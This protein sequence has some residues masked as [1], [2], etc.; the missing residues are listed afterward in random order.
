MTAIVLLAICPAMVFCMFAGRSISKLPVP[1]ETATLAK[2]RRPVTT[3]RQG[4][5]P[6]PAQTLTPKLAL[7]ER[8]MDGSLARNV[9]FRASVDLAPTP[10][11]R[12]EEPAHAADDQTVATMAAYQEGGNSGFN[13]FSLIMRPGGQAPPVL[14]PG[15]RLKPLPI[16]GEPINV[17]VTKETPPPPMRR[18][19][20]MPVKSEPIRAIEGA[21][22][23]GEDD[24]AALSHALGTASLQPGERLEL[25][26]G[27]VTPG[28]KSPHILLARLTR[29]HD[30]DRVVVRMDDGKFGD[31][32]NPAVYKRMVA[33]ALAHGDEPRVGPTVLRPSEKEALEAARQDFPR[34]MARLADNDVPPEVGLQVVS[35]LRKNGIELNDD[36]DLPPHLDM[37]FR[38]T[39]TGH[40]DLVFLNCLVGNEEKRF[41]RYK[42]SEDGDAEFFDEH[43][44]SVSKILMHNPVPDSRRN[45]GFGWRIHPILKRPEFHNGVDF[46]APMGTPILAA[47]DGVVTKISW[48]SGYG[49]YVR[50]K[51]D[52]G[53]TTTYAHISRA[54]KDLKV[55]DRVTQGEVIA[56]IGST[57]LSTGPH[58]YY[59]LRVG[60]KYADPTK[61]HIEAGTVLHGQELDA[62]QQQIDHVRS[63]TNTITNSVR[64]A[65]SSVYNAADQS[66]DNI[67]AFAG[68]LR[69]DLPTGDDRMA[70]PPSGPQSMRAN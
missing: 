12:P 4:R 14:K 66:I 11:A 13:P 59:E 44:R 6:M 2:K 22:D 5:V 51:H 64:L 25:I 32:P 35:L 27:D 70:L 43:G 18:I 30:R 38:R 8:R 36:G 52:F 15:S 37:V 41:Y 3:R 39:S 50:I 65:A 7:L 58:L 26:I 40:A 47:G 42:L 29:P 63:I 21:L 57:G 10:E 46:D 16:R 61:A 1:V 9:Y 45:D 54:A 49:K 28:T 68:H 53:Y 24:W 62:F 56:Y 48:E 23:I 19:V 31:M 67:E 20:A 34:L 33:E 55:G 17:S 69:P 60:D